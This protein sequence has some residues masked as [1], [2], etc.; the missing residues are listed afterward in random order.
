MDAD[1]IARLETRLESA[2]RSE[3][4]LVRDLHAVGMHATTV[5]EGI[6]VAVVLKE[7]GYISECRDVF[8]RLGKIFPGNDQ[9]VFEHIQML[10]RTEQ[11]D[12]ADDLLVATVVGGEIGDNVFR[13][14]IGRTLLPNNSPPERRMRLISALLVALTRSLDGYKAGIVNYL[15]MND[16]DAYV[17]EYASRYL[18]TPEETFNR[19]RDAITS[20]RPFCLLRL[21]DGE[22]AFIRNDIAPVPQHEMTKDHMQFFTNRW[23]G[24]I[25]LANEP[26]FRDLGRELREGLCE[27]DIIGVPDLAWIQHEI[28]MRNLR[29]FVN[30]L[31]IVSVVNTLPSGMTGRLVP[32]TVAIDLEYRGLMSQLITIAGSIVLIT[33]H[34]RLRDALE[35]KLAIHV[36]ETIS[37]PYARSDAAVTGYTGHQSH[38]RQAYDS[39][40]AEIDKLEP[41]QVVLV[42]AGFLG[43]LY[44]LRL[45][46]RGCVAI[47]IGSLADLWLGHRTRPS[48]HELDRLKLV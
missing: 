11:F 28:N 16:V 1:H 5:S 27:A 3:L 46:R 21:G 15:A 4:D 6:H 23:Y 12:A 8:D 10:R 43:K 19:C 24:D 37:I 17:K 42:G 25:E 41:G 30:C 44:A 9:V 40:N 18:M 29:T 20:R 13:E 39:V 32:T 22:G 7:K 2:R 14:I 34:D 47:D 45:K 48:F 33:S 36:T 31:E 38:Y 35:R 26:A